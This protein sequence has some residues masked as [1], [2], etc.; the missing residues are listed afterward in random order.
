MFDLVI[1]NGT[2]VSP[3]SS[4]KIDI[5][6]KDGKISVLDQLGDSVEAKEVIDATGKHI[7]PG[8]ID[9]HMH[10]EAPF[11]G[12]FGANDF[13]TQSVSAAF[14]GVTT[15]MDFTNTFPGNSVITQ[16]EE[17]KDEMSKSALDYSIHCK[18]VEAPERILQEIPK[19]I[20][21]GSPSFK[22][23]M[24]Y[25]KE[26]V[27][28]DDETLLKVFKLAKEYGGLPLLHAESN[29]IAESNI[30]E[31]VASNSLGWQSFASSKPVLCETEAV[32][33]ATLFSEYCGNA[34]LFVHTTNKPSL[35]IAR[36]AQEC[37]LPVYVETCPH[38]LTLFD[39]MYASEERGHLAICSP[40]LRTPKEAKEL[41]DG[42]RD[43]TICVTG[44][45]DCTY[46]IKEKEMF[47]ERDAQGKI[48]P[49]FRKIVNGLSGCE[50]RLPVLLSEGVAKGRISINRLVELTSTN[51]AKLSGCYPQKGCL[52]PGSD[53]DITIVDL[54][55]K[56]VLSP[57]Q[58]HNNI[59]YCL[60]DG[61]E[62]TG[63]VD[64]TIA[65]G[66]IV[67]Q[68]KDFLGK[69]DSGRFIK[70]SIAESVLTNHA[71]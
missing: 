6:I 39:D 26:G 24:T 36:R 16:F 27:M 51:V 47:L 40:P 21:M 63:A 22:M 64:T 19:L 2:V 55:R 69:R 29:A 32:S 58:L 49:D 68:G 37:G 60:H 34:V 3:E 41:W 54:S 44:S 1:K 61:L 12:C 33:R 7:L 13:Y 10:V 25:R 11:Q 53:A 45:D 14:G 50:I 18:F 8:V 65:R 30:E 70:R 56:W 71:F 67:V 52:A 4:K 57:E 17:R 46:S 28:S 43:G 20:D 23:F 62:L 31:C 59:D 66:S 35:D 38:Y 5:G 9:A 15:I 42:L 48:I